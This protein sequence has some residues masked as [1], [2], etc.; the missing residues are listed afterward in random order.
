MILGMLA[1]SAAAQPGGDVVMPPIPPPPDQMPP[2]PEPQPPPQHHLQPPPPYVQPAYVQPQ[3]P[4][5]PPPGP[6]PGSTHATFVS[7][8]E[9]RF[10][11]RIDGNAACTTP[12]ALVVEPMRFV[13]LHSQEDRPAKLSVG[14]LSGRAVVV[15]AKPREQ[16]A[17]A[18]GVTFTSLA[19][20]GVITGITLTSVGCSTSRDGMCT[21]GLIT[22]VAS[23]VGLYLSIG[24]I[25]RSL[26]SV[27]VGPAQTQPYVTANGAGFS[28]RF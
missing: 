20:A 7:T 13:T 6:A 14:H 19:G 4:Q 23:G 17:F 25:R 15:Q 18:A 9:L 24:L 21:A 1:G 5:Q 12:C 11:V 22:G 2:P 3:Y 16:G 27:R 10:D 26:A 28:G 8:G